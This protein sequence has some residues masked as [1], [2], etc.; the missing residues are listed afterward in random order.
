[1]SVWTTHRDHGTATWDEVSVGDRIV[2]ST[3]GPERTE[4]EGS[5]VALTERTVTIKPW[6]E[7]PK[8]DFDVDRI[9]RQQ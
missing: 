8:G 9:F 5:V 7:V 4:I 1:M 6:I 2:M 3:R